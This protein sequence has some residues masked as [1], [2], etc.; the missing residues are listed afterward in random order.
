MAEADGALRAE[1][2]KVRERARL[3]VMA[4]GLDPE[5]AELQ[6][7]AA[8]EE[9]C[10]RWGIRPEM[11]GPGLLRGTRPAAAPGKEG[12]KRV[13]LGASPMRTTINPSQ[14]QALRI[15]DL[16]K[17]AREMEAAASGQP[18]TPAPGTPAS[19]TPAPGSGAG[20][21]HPPAPG[22]GAGGGVMRTTGNLSSLLQRVRT[23]GLPPASG[24]APSSPPAAQ[25]GAAPAPTMRPSPAPAP[26]AP[27]R[28]PSAPA[29]A[30]SVPL[31]AMPRPTGAFTSRGMTSS[32]PLGGTGSLTANAE[33][34]RQVIEEFDR[35]YAEVQTM[36]EQRIGVVDVALND[37]SKGLTGA[38]AKAQAG[39]LDAQELEVL[40]VDVDRLHQHLQVMMS[41]C[42]EFLSHLQDFSIRSEGSGQAPGGRA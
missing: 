10:A 8:V 11:L 38:M 30:P 37:A 6:A 23:Q 15:G 18:L 36:L 34:R 24:P 42:E 32:D 22:L 1:I 40:A 9:F 16:L 29:P 3:Q 35:T 28:G 25:R 31:P 12:P 20:P 19:G 17:K 4:Q 2:E 14:T 5:A 41:L 33:R 39:G 13:D 27:P 26:A 21:G 7:D